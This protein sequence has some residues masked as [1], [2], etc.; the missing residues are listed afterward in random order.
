MEAMF[1]KEAEENESETDSEPTIRLT[2]SIVESFEK[3]HLKK[4]DF[5][6]EKFDYV[7]LIE[8]QIKEQKRIAELVKA[9]MSKKEEEFGKDELVDLLGINVVT[10]VY[11]SKIKY[12]KYC[13]KILNKIALGKITN[14]DVFLKGKGPITLKVY[15]VIGLPKSTSH[16][17]SSSRTVLNEPTLDFTK[18]L[19][20]MIMLGPLV[21][22]YL[23][24]LI[25]GT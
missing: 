22:S 1:H 17:S 19:A 13:D 21:P 14:C 3:K 16:Q 2:G 8:E 4:F 12:D 24:K 7:H 5:V 20:K 9:G 6:T 23:L 18:D 11:K 10:I 25:E 15:R